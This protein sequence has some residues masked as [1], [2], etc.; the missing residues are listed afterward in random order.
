MSHGRSPMRR[1]AP[2]RIAF[3]LVILI[4]GAI[5]CPGQTVEFVGR[6]IRS[7]D[8]S[9]PGVLH[10]ADLERVSVLKVGDPLRAEDAAEAIDRL[11]ATGRFEDIAIEA[12]PLGDGV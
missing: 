11:F 5:L 6:P 2:F 10:P 12:T 1:V 8:Y 7:I 3:F 9:H 4:F